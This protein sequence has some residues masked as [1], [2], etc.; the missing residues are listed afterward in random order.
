MWY[1]L[2]TYSQMIIIVYFYIEYRIIIDNNYYIYWYVISCCCISA[3]TKLKQPTESFIHFKDMCTDKHWGFNFTSAEDAAKFRD[4]VL[5]SNSKFSLKVLH[6][7][8]CRVKIR[9][10][11]MTL[12]LC[13]DRGKGWAGINFPGQVGL[14]PATVSIIPQS[15]NYLR[16]KNRHQLGYRANQKPNTKQNVCA[17]IRTSCTS[18]RESVLGCVH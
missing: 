7:P 9:P 4:T 14:I 1:M 2:S 10:C 6:R 8:T 3:G 13:T 11:P 16:E 17:A 12:F 18:A 5:V 15:V